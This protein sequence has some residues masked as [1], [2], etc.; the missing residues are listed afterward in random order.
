GLGAGRYG[1][2]QPLVADFANTVLLS[3]LVSGGC[4]CV[5]DPALAA[6]AA[7]VA[8]F[9]ARERVDYLKLVPSHLVAL[10]AGGGLQRLLPARALIL[11]GEAAAVSWARDLV[12]AAGECRVANH[13]GPTETTVGVASGFLDGDVLA[14]EVV[15]LGRALPNDRLYVVDGSLR[16]V[17]VGVVG[18]LL[19]GGLGVARG[20]VGQ[21]DLTGQ[22]FVADPFAGG[23][24]RAYRT[25]DRVRRR[26]D[27]GVEFLGR[28]D[29]Q[30]KV[31]GYR[32]EA[33]EVEAVLL[34]H[35]G[36]R[37]AVVTADG[38]DAGRRLVAYLVAPDG[39]PEPTEL[40]DWARRFLP[41]YMVPAVFVEL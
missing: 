33:A 36:V 12:T 34:R 19:V 11:G 30:L 32:I 35:A 22:R 39:L 40:R 27:G 31:R 20:Y 2:V 1:L 23:G 5:L 37:A 9:V 25:G 14:G 17:P 29:T 28:V 10:A 41:E 21:P 16:P 38:S 3:S 15:P 26:V 24:A 6:D 18:E 8:E 7:A 4:L 13:Y